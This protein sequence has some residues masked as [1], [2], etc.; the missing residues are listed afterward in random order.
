MFSSLRWE[1][2]DTGVDSKGRSETE[3]EGAELGAWA[4]A[5]GARG[6][7]DTERRRDRGLLLRPVCVRAADRHSF[8]IHA[9]TN[10]ISFDSCISVSTLAFLHTCPLACSDVCLTH[11]LRLQVTPSPAA[12]Q[13]DP[14][15]FLTV[16]L[17]RKPY[18]AHS[19]RAG[20][21]PGLIRPSPPPS[22]SAS[23]RDSRLL[24]SPRL[25]HA[26]AL[27]RDQKTSGREGTFLHGISGRLA[28][29]TEFPPLRHIQAWGE[30][31]KI[32]NT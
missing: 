9:F 12:A 30:G 1:E 5:E 22:R 13:P 4:A 2:L 18:L 19:W 20:N 8:C 24:P 17:V 11:S 6:V 25:T 14:P 23:F 31:R 28:Y 15:F 32:R 27:P 3:R 10:H 26:L 16:F 7:V 21:V 29:K